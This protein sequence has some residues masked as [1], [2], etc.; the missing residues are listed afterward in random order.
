MNQ[1]SQF[2]LEMFLIFREQG[3]VQIEE[4]SC[5]WNVLIGIGVSQPD[6]GLGVSRGF[7]LLGTTDIQC[8][9]IISIHVPQLTSENLPV[10]R[11]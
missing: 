9:S 4:K 1:T 3:I 7:P 8:K 6:L 11:T 10:D 5:T 2:G